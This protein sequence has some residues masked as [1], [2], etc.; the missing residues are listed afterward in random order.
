MSSKRGD[1]LR[2]ETGRVR[3]P[4]YLGGDEVKWRSRR[5]SGPGFQERGEHAGALGRIN[6]KHDAECRERE[7]GRASERATACE[8][9][10]LP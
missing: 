6:R 7:R 8:S 5:K 3:G 10:S 1:E 9:S 4:R 2:E